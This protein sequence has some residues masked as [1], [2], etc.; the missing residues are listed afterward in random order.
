LIVEFNQYDALLRSIE[1]KIHAL[2]SAGKGEA[3]RRLEQ[4]FASLKVCIHSFVSFQYI[5]RLQRSFYDLIFN[6]NCN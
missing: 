5:K 4:Q 1:D 6:V 3:A 2:R